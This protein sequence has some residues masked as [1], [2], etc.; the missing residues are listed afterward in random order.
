MDVA[1]SGSSGLIGGA[2]C[3]RLEERGDTVRRLVRRPADSPREIRWD[4]DRGLLDPGRLEG[5]NAVAHLAGA[6]IAN[7]HWTRS[8]MDLILGSRTRGTHLISSA[9]AE[10]RRAGT[11][12]GILVSGS[13]I[14]FYGDRPDEPLDETSARGGGF[15]ADVCVAWEAATRTAESAGIRVAHARTG[16][17]LSSR[18]GLLAAQ[19]PLFRLGLGGPLGP[20]TQWMSWISLSDE[21]SALCWLIDNEVCGPAN[22][23]SPSPVTNAGFAASLGSAVRR[24]A[25]IRTPALVPSIPFGRRLVTELM[26]SSAVVRPSVLLDGGFCFSKPSLDEVL[27][28]ELGVP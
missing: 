1:V 21:V 9:M 5:V 14:G 8:R 23:V 7:R 25:R 19:L 24:P 17:V 6:G 11:G 13:A 12:P 4:P 15:L 28:S 26:L 22:L 2:L 18:G 20:G 10:S 27:R 16:I 3:D